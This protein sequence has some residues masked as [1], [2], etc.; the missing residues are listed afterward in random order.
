MVLQGTVSPMDTMLKNPGL[1]IHRVKD[2]LE[3]LCNNVF[4]EYWSGTVIEIQPLLDTLDKA[5]VARGS[6]AEPSRSDPVSLRAKTQHLSLRCAT[7]RPYIPLSPGSSRPLNCLSAFFVPGS[8][9]SLLSSHPPPFFVPSHLPRIPDAH[10][11]T[12]YFKTAR[13]PNTSKQGSCVWPDTIAWMVR[14]HISTCSA[15]NCEELPVK[16]P[17]L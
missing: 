7:P 15:L 4:G 5:V 17:Q 6:L 3:H 9:S 8:S 11:G 13:T 2:N 10:L 14:H 12:L 16:N 1:V